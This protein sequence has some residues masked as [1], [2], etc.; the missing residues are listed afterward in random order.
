MIIYRVVSAFT[1]RQKY[2]A[3]KKEVVEYADADDGRIVQALTFP[4]NTPQDIVDLINGKG[5]GPIDGL[6]IYPV[7]V[8]AEQKHPMTTQ[9]RIDIDSDDSGKIANEVAQVAFELANGKR[10]GEADK[11]KWLC[12]VTNEQKQYTQAEINEL[13]NRAARADAEWQKE[14]YGQFKDLASEVRYY[15]E[16]QGKPGSELRR[17]H[18][19]FKA[20]MDD[21]LT[22]CRIMRERK[23]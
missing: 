2:F 7:Y 23:D 3:T 12:F 4:V 13:Y 5:I 22:A 21:F 6:N 1:N 18:D 8:V 14:L 10:G 16:G 20:A 17:L 11:V 15:P 9:I 19:A